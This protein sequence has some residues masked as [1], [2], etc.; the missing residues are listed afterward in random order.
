MDLMALRSETRS[1]KDPIG[2]S[3]ESAGDPWDDGVSEPLDFVRTGSLSL[4]SLFFAHVIT[5]R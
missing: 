5:L 1:D 2:W 3:I 4:V